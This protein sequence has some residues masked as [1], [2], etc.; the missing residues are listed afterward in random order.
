MYIYGSSQNGCG[1]HI[2]KQNS[3]RILPTCSGAAKPANILAHLSYQTEIYRGEKCQH[4]IT[5]KHI[6]VGYVGS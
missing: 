6:G 4:G 2:Y 3:S 5:T 1:K